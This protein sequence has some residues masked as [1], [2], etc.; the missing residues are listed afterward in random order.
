MQRNERALRA[1]RSSPLEPLGAEGLNATG[2]ED[3]TPE[4]EFDGTDRPAEP[5]EEGGK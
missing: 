2:F 4:A 1:A 5:A 3:E